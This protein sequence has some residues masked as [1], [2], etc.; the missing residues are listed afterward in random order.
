MLIGI[1]IIENERFAR[2]LDR[3]PRLAERIF[4]DT[5]RAYC[6][7]KPNPP[8]HFAARFAAKEAVG[9]ALGTGVRA[10]RE[11]EITSGGKPRVVMTGGTGR[12][13]ME[14][15]ACELSISISHCGNV[16]VAVAAAP[17]P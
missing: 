5:E 8:Q 9:K 6:L 10:W 1:D 4:T 12:V 3:R 13:A 7:S 16:S 14:L 17:G 2:A 11:I 15:G